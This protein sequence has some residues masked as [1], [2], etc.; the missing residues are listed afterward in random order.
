MLESPLKNRRVFCQVAHEENRLRGLFP[1]L[2]NYISSYICVRLLKHSILHVA[3]TTGTVG[4]SSC[5]EGY[6]GLDKV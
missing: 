5:C 3:C 6:I 4:E 1:V 2:G